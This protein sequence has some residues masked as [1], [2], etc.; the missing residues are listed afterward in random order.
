MNGN[1]YAVDIAMMKVARAPDQLYSLGLGSCIGVAIYDPKAKI[2]GL[3][4]IL[5]PSSQGFE[6]GN[7][8]RTKFADSGIM[9]LVEALLKAGASRVR[10]KAKMAGGASMFTIKSTSSIHEVGKRNI[11]SSKDTLK[12][13]GI[14][15]VAHDTGGNKG[16]TIIFDIDTGQL[17]IKT[18]DRAVKVI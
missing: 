11:Q 14:E 16:R 5:L 3:I 4:H 1:S 12:M 18:V 8:V 15:L 6:N 17:T 9:D 7:H 2:G 13:L 10:L